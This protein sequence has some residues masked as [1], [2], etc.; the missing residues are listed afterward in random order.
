MKI[1]GERFKNSDTCEVVSFTSEQAE[2]DIA[3][4]Y[5]TGR[6]P[7]TG[8]WAMNE[9]ADEMVAVIEGEGR[10]ILKDDAVIE[11]EAGKGA[12]VQAGTLFAWDGNMTLSMSCNPK[13]DSSKYKLVEA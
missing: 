10:L 8:W 3:F 1:E 11:L 2:H 5:I 6:Y 9:D 4:V 12:F 13:F 7:D